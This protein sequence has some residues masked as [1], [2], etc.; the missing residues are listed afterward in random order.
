[1]QNKSAI[2]AFTILL[3]LACLYQLSF[4]WVVSGVESEAER[5]ADAKLDSVLQVDTTGLKDDAFAQDSVRNIYLNQFLYDQGPK[6]VYPLLGFDYN[7]C[8]RFKINLGL[9]LQGGMS[10]T[11]E[12]EVDKLLKNLSGGD[13]SQIFAEAIA[14]AKKAQENDQRDFVTL[15]GEAWEELRTG[16]NE[17]ARLADIFHNRD[18]KEEFPLSDSDE[19][20][21]DKL[22]TKAQEAVENSE[23]VLRKR[24]DNLGV[25]Q[26]KI[27]RLSG[28]GRIIIEL[29]GIKDSRRVTKLLQ[30]SAKLE[31]WEVHKNSP[32]MFNRLVAIDTLL[33]DI[34]YPGLID[35]IR[36]N[37]A[38]ADA[39]TAAIDPVT[40]DSG[41]SPEAILADGGDA[42][43]EGQD[44]LEVDSNTVD[45]SAV[46][47]ASAAPSPEDIL[48]SD[49]TEETAGAG[50]GGANE[51]TLNDPRLSPLFRI[52]R[53]YL[54]VDQSTNQQ[55]IEPAGYIGFV[56]VKDTGKV[57][58]F[59]RM[60][61]VQAVMPDDVQYAWSAKGDE[62]NNY[63]LYVLNVATDDGKAP[64]E[65]DVVTNARVENNQQGTPEVNLIMNQEGANTW[66]RLTKKASENKDFIA[67]VL[68]GLVYSAP[69]VNQE[70]GGGS[71]VIQGGFTVEE[72]D[73]LAN[74][75]KAGKLEVPSEI[76]ERQYV[77]PSLGREAVQNGLM[78]FVIALILILIYMMFYYSRAGMVADIAL[79]ANLFFVIGVLASL[80]ATL[81]LPGIA[82]IVLT[83][84]MSVD[85]N[86]L[87]YERIREEL[88]EGKGLRL[89]IVD[90]Y[91]SA[92][93]SIIDAN[94]T[95][96]LTGI[97][98]YVFGTGPIQ[99]FATT[100]IIGIMTSLFSAIFI[101]RLVFEWRLKNNKPITF[102]TKMTEGAFKNLAI[103]FIVRR[104]LYYIISGAIIIGGIASLSVN[105]LNYGV[106][107][108]GGR[109]YQVKFEQAPDIDQVGNVLEAQ[110]ISEQGVPERPEVKI[111]GNANRIKITTKHMI[112]SAQKGSVADSIVLSKLETG[113]KELNNNYK[114]ERVQKVESTIADDI[115]QSAIFSVIFALII[116]FLY[117]LFRFRKW[118][119]GVGALIAMFHDV[120]VV[121]GIFSIFYKV[122]PFSMEI[123]QAFIA[124]IL[125]VVG[126]SIN[127]T[128][129]VFDRIREYLGRYKKKEMNEVVNSALNST[130]SRTI[131][132]S[133]STFFVLLM[134]FIFGG[135]SIRG[136]VFALMIG[137]VVGTYS[138][139]CVATPVV[140]DFNTKKDEP[141]K[142]R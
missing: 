140:I 85:A 46:D 2:W 108:V 97:V 10:V 104:K 1:M 129:V 136:F 44:S 21:L 107:F 42:S 78:S 110:F 130:L 29:P 34:K 79:V 20:V 7:Y 96:L 82:G 127:D 49:D 137:V 76:I 116:I 12:L 37:Q 4:T 126:Y 71:S 57:N 31:F 77:G 88:S 75:L 73:D 68:D 86:V 64:L 55:Y 66:R 36:A 51:G 128:V 111:F 14:N 91:N 56:N 15:F 98:L 33:R 135:E 141:A 87:I 26:P 3:T 47:S 92:Y 9:D 80:G 70:I 83:I 62:N 32:D 125:T 41:A 94:L 65:G 63:R 52:F 24:I 50:A 114:I 6:P 100:L 69:I 132:T 103:K 61:E 25:V 133:L 101:T 27:E 58:T 121:L 120:L 16:G 38:G 67:I 28:S 45:S 131:N 30:G 81:T 113:L 102:A 54:R 18:N 117:I 48:N 60:E 43:P 72:A 115:Q 59:F 142:K 22:R 19:D 119:F 74:V 138:S 5:F 118:Q 123:D 109:N 93:S 99:G 35:S 106:E 23:R 95:T 13:D 139:L 90:G 124:A 53:P 84:G 40:P 112:A 105:G 122:M 134:I 39:A 89:A 8:K 17:N 11:L